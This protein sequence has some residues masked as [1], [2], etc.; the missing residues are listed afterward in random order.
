VAVRRTRRS[1]LAAAFLAIGAVAL[2]NAADGFEPAP[3]LKASAVAPAALFKGP[4]HEL[5]PTAKCDGFLLSFDVKSEYG[6]W[7]AIDLEMLNV[8]VEEV[9]SLAQLSDVSKTEIFAQA[10]G[11][12]SA[13]LDGRRL[14]L[15]E[16][17]WSRR[18]FP[19]VAGSRLA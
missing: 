18:P 1:A 2:A 7:E 3:T 19:R 6:T 10:F 16:V 9:C 8:R 11:K 15:G 12:V 5:G 17:K 13:S 4:K 14:L